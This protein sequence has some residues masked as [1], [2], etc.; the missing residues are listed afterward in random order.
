MT[1]YERLWR[2][3]SRGWMGDPYFH[4]PKYRSADA[5]RAPEIFDFTSLELFLNFISPDWANLIFSPNRYSDK[6]N[7]TL[8]ARNKKDNS[9]QESSFEKS[10]ALFFDENGS[11]VPENLEKEVLKLHA[12]L[13][14]AKKNK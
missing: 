4:V 2:K 3:Q 7:L 11:L 1:P 13:S 9:R 10:I 12:S 6:Y 8:V 14:S 5:L